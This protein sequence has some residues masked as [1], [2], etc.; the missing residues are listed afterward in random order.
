MAQSVKH[1]TLDPG[2]DHDLMVSWVR[3][4]PLA[5]QRQQELAWDSLSPSPT[6]ARTLS[7]KINNK[8]QK[9]LKEI[10]KMKLY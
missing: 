2:S 10:M 6:W 1:L 8:H 5:L 7:L 4:P 9:K 3:A